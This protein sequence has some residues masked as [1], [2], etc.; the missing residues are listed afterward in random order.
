MCHVRMSQTT[1]SYK[2][3][4]YLATSMYGT[5]LVLSPR[6]QITRCLRTPILLLLFPP[7]ETLNLVLK[8]SH[9]NAP[10]R[11]KLKPT[12]KASEQKKRRVGGR[13]TSIVA[14]TEPPYF[15]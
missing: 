6:P 8:F 15:I 14:L 5:G 4:T 3:Q 1:Q 13:M 10:R 7:T 9:F 2:T 12:K 11:E